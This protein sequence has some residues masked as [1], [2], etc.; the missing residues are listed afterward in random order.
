MNPFAFS[1]LLQS[2]DDRLKRNND[3]STKRNAVIQHMFSS[4]GVPP[5]V[6][7]KLDPATQQ[8]LQSGSKAEKEMYLRMINDDISGRSNTLDSAVKFLGEQYSNTI[9][10]AEKSKAD[11]VAAITKVGSSPA[12]LTALKALYP[13]YGSL[14]D[15]LAASGTTTNAGNIGGYDISSYATDPNHETAVAS[16]YNNVQNYANDPDKLQ[17]Y[18]TQI[19]PSSPVT[20]QMIIDSANQYGVDPA[21]VTSL[22]Q[23][24]SSFGTAGKAV[25]TLNP[26]NVGND[27]AGNTKK[28]GSWNEGVDAVAQ[29]LSN[30]RSTQEDPTQSG[31]ILGATGLSPFANMILIGQT[32]QVP[33]AQR[34]AAQNELKAWSIKNGVDTSTF[35]AEYAAYNENVQK[36]IARA[37]QTQI[38]AGEVTGSADSLMGVIDEKDLANLKIKNVAK[39]FAGKET[40]DPLVQ[41]YSTQL[42][43]MQ[44]DLAGYLAAARGATSPELQDQKDA[45]EVI[46]NGLSK[47]SVQAFKDSIT[48]NEEK[49]SGV[50]NKAVESAQKS[51]W[52]LY[53]AGDKYKSASDRAAA[54]NGKGSLDDR[55]FVE[56]A[57]KN[58]GQTYDQ[59]VKTQVPKGEVLVVDNKT[60]EIGHIPEKE[61]NKS[62]YTYL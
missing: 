58:S 36:N 28:F 56:K 49:V 60:G 53:G 39:L 2:M 42:H 50:V 17:S 19:A 1:Q 57:V 41:K 38:M 4:D 27:D 48:A 55:S 11:A 46:T 24:D 62:D 12:A 16:I 25:G 32:K 47:R 26:G 23:Q 35:P 3:L 33:A 37:N 9:D 21:L 18:I 29:W 31:S 5:D 30:H 15:D 43:F 6:M 22:I 13:Q 8:V 45:A 10:Q 52:D 7:S 54:K 40:N 14:F 34:N 44:N 59:L 20:A 51:I 61:F